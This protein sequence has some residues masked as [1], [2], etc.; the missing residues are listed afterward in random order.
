VNYPKEI[1]R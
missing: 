1:A